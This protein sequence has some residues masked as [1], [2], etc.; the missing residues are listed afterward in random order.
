MELFLFFVYLK[1]N[2]SSSSPVVRKDVF[3]F[4]LK[5]RDDFGTILNE[6][7]LESGIEIGVKDGTLSE[8]LLSKW[9]S[10]TKYHLIDPWMQQKNYVDIANQD[11]E[12]QLAI[13]NEAKKKLKK[14]G[15][16]RLNFIRDFSINAVKYFKNKSI[17]FVYVDSRHD[18]CSV[19]EDLELYYPVLKCGGLMAGHDYIDVETQKSL[20]SS[21]DWSVCSDGKR[22]LKHGGAVKGKRFVKAFKNFSLI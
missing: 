3:E 5:H 9:T 17:D 10:F 20:D 18:Y 6:L 11:T 15:S 16:D 1:N 22:V 21:Q 19:L 7:G 13:M 8:T 14:F 12:K 4:N 2:K